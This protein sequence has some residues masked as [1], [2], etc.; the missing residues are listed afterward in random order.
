MQLLTWVRRIGFCSF[1][2]IYLFFYSQ[3][4]FQV[5]I[6]KNIP[7]GLFYKLQT[8]SFLA[9]Q[10]KKEGTR[11]W[12]EVKFAATQ[13]AFLQMCVKSEHI[14]YIYLLIFAIQKDSNSC[15]WIPGDSTYGFSWYQQNVNR[16]LFS[17]RNV[18]ISIVSY[19]YNERS[20]TCTNK[21]KTP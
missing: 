12:I 14:T 8:I 21:Q 1:I 20:S 4:F 5:C 15:I 7:L 13:K 9:E 17:W 18:L 3:L 19:F 16:F 10:L 11:K 2:F 6:G